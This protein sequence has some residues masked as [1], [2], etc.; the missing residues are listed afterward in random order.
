VPDVVLKRAPIRL[1]EIAR[2]MGG[3]DAVD[4]RDL[5]RDGDPPPPPR[6]RSMSLDF[7]TRGAPNSGTRADEDR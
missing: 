6:G 7:L 2:E 5:E 1:D 3:G 4:D